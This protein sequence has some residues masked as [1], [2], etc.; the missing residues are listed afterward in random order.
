MTIALSIP[1]E[2]GLLDKGRRIRTNCIEHGKLLECP[3][4]EFA[5]FMSVEIQ[6]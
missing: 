1:F 3:S 6:P 5:L 4:L 2:T